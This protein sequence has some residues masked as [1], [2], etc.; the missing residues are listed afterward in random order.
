MDPMAR[1][2]VVTGLGVIVGSLWGAARLAEALRGSTMACSEVDRA[3]GYHLAESARLAVL[4]TGLDLSAWVPPAAGRRMSP[5]SKLGV[6]A[7]RMA[8]EDAGLLGEVGGPRTTVVM[9][10]A[11]GAVEF[12]ERLLRSVVLEGPETA[13]PFLFTESVANA[14]AAQIAIANQAQGP[15][16]TVVQREAGVLIAAGRGAAEVAAGRADRALVG[17]VEEMPPLL[18]AL[19]D[20]FEALARPG[21][22]G[23]EVARPFDRRRNGFMAAEGAVVLVLE[24]EDRARA[25]GARVHARVRGAGGAFDPSAPRVGWGHGHEGLARALRAL[26]D[27]VG[28]APRDVRRIVSGASGSVAGDRLEARTLRAAWGA[29][30]LPAILAPKS[31]TGEYGGGLLASAVLAASDHDFGPTGGFREP[32]PELRVTPHP[33]GPLPDAPITLVTSLASGGTASWLVL[34]RP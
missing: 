20:R 19:L 13:S 10:T 28:L 5:P 32:D 14:A 3:A 31:V 11:F 12:T 29:E 18:H 7:A 15:N 25:R 22:A 30:A 9:S 4:T 8:V 2:V 6:A 16:L 1:G 21:T 23:G 26:L 24:A 33:G 27:R 17:A 34:E